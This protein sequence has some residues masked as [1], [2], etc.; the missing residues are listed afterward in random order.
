MNNK[1]AILI[2]IEPGLLEQQAE[3]LIKSIHKY[4]TA[5]I[6]IF[7]FSPRVD[8]KPGSH[9]ESFLKYQ[10]THHFNSDLNIDYPDFPLANG[11]YAS[12]F[13][14][15]EQPE[16]SKI[17]LTDTDTV[18]I[19]NLPNEIF[20]N[21]TVFVSPA[22]NKGVGSEGN[23][24]PEDIFWRQM[25][26]FFDIDLP[27]A[28]MTTTV[29]NNT[30]RPYHNSGFVLVNGIDGFYQQWFKDFDELMKSNIRPKFVGRDGT[31]FGFFE[32]LVLSITTERIINK[33]RFFPRQLNYPIPFQPY[34]SSEKRSLDF[35]ELCH[36]HYHKWFQHP[37]F[38]DHVTTDEDKKTEQYRWLKEQLP[39][40]PTIDG[41]FKC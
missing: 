20:E 23:D 12:S 39:L 37:G 2:I 19:N 25:F 1:L 10:V 15:R 3:L 30:I 24:D 41:P 9:M 8:R 14:E 7:T 16:Y 18:F 36:I 28:N 33:K 22:D 38:L 11:L 21:N 40:Q 26:E 31:N 32:Q 13:F 17:L 35:N 27:E 6:D 34:L 29:R 4:L 5:E